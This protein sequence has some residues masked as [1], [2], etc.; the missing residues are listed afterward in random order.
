MR[1]A[2]PLLA[3][4]ALSLAVAACGDD[5]DGSASGTTAGGGGEAASGTDAYCDAMVAFN[6]AVFA[7]ELDDTSTAADI[8]AVGGE[9]GPLW[10]AIDANAPDDVRAE[11]D[12]LT[13]AIDGLA[14]GDAEAF[15]ADASFE[16]YTVLSEKTVGV[17]GFENNDVVA[18]D[19]AFEDVPESVE[20]GTV[21]FTLK[22]E[23]EEDH[24]MLLF[25]KAPGETRSAE[26]I[27]N[28][29]AIQEEGPPGE[30]AGAAF[31]PPGGEGATFS[32]LTAGDYVMV[33]FVPTGGDEEAPPHAAQG[34]YAEFS[35]S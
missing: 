19:Y 27:L 22:N 13:P 33:C 12:Q 16:T 3:L 31:A 29:P 10:E 34:M 14:E 9:L 2:L 17:C 6:S 28:D 24:E 18:V 26:E 15:N 21:A 20:A 23:G 4:A 1:R 5:D 25:K 35:V 7:V 8:E 32:E 30:F 11:V